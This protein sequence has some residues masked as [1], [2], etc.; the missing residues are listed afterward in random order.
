[1]YC[2]FYS[3]KPFTLINLIYFHVLYTFYHLSDYFRYRIYVFHSDYVDHSLYPLITGKFK[4]ETK[5][6]ITFVLLLSSTSKNSLLY[7]SV[8]IID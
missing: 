5:Q 2:H 1:M 4:E 7:L 3:H 6:Y 8:H